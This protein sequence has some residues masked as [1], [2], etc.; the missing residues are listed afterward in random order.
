VVEGPAVPLLER[1]LEARHLL[2]DPVL[3]EVSPVATARRCTWMMSP[4]CGS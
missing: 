3:F 2:L 1:C 4:V